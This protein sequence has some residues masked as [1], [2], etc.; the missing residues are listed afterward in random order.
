MTQLENIFNIAMYIVRL[1]QCRC[2]YCAVMC[3]VH[4][5]QSNL[6]RLSVRSVENDDLFHIQMITVHAHPSH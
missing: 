2:I 3:I 5:I 6:R 1:A 4:V